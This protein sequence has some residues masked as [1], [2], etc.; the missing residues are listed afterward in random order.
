MTEIFK[1]QQRLFI[2]GPLD[3]RRRLF[4]VPQEMRRVLQIPRFA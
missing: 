3:R 4:V 1:Q 2:K